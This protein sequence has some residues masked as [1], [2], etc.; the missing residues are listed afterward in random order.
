[1]SHR[2][3]LY[4][5]PDFKSVELLVIS[6]LLSHH[7][8]TYTCLYKI[9]ICCSLPH[10]HWRRS[11]FTIWTHL[12]NTN[13]QTPCHELYSAIQIATTGH[14]LWSL[15]K[16]RVDKAPPNSAWETLSS[17]Q[18]TWQE[19]NETWEHLMD[20]SCEQSFPQYLFPTTS[21]SPLQEYYLPFT[22]A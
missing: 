5:R 3:G 17:L 20:L 11:L 13:S 19:R 6:I 9:R 1:M 12:P 21:F 10:Y 15:P 14:T 22:L 7:F 4:P 18:Y 2:I 16:G 8:F